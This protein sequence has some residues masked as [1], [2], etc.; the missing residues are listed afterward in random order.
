MKY[1]IIAFIC[2]IILDYIF[3]DPYC[4]PHPVRYIGNLISALEKRHFC[5]PGKKRRLGKCLVVE[6]CLCVELVVAFILIGGYLIHPI[7]GVFIESV[8]TYQIFAAKSLK[9]ESMKVHKALV[10][11]S[12]EDARRAVSMIV[13]RDTES[14]NEEQIA[15]A[16]VETVAENTC[17]GVIAPAIYLALGG[18]MLGFLYK[19]INTMDSMVGYKN[20]KYIDYG[21]A[22]AKTDDVVNYIPSRI[23]AWLMILNCVWLGK[24]YDAKNAKK[25]FK[26]DRYNH[27][28]PNSAQT[29]AAW[30]GALGVQLAGDASYFGKIY[31]KP[32]IGDS[33]RKI[34]ADDIKRAN[35]LMYGTA[36]TCQIICVAL[37]MCFL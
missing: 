23:S 31:K 11:G 1:H 22:A 8:M 15:K 16:A 14:L 34:E 21:R 19:S 33:L 32:Y 36:I 13:G 35:I 24:N 3:G 25:I 29:E 26:R 6:V 20:D 7:L 12:I 10:S 37:L 5:S 28:S 30:A 9:V 27:A 17:D 2:G 18:P 4:V